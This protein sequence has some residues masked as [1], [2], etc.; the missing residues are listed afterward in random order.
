MLTLFVIFK[1]KSWNW[2]GIPQVKQLDNLRWFTKSNEYK[3]GAV[4]Y[5]DS[6]NTKLPNNIVQ[7]E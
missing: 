6:K 3:R 5:F 7:F 4:Y 1:N 2:H